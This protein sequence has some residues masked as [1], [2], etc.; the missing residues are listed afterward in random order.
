MRAL[1]AASA[2]AVLTA[3]F[4]PGNPGAG[5]DPDAGST[6]GNATSDAGTSDAGTSDAGI[7][8]AGSG[9][10]SA[11]AALA[12]SL[13][14]NPQFL[15]G[16]GND[17]RGAPDYD[18]NKDGAYTL[19]S[20]LDL[21]YAYLAGLMGSGGW[22]DWNA[23]GTFVNILADTAAAHGVTPMFTLYSMA[24]SGEGNLS[25]L[26]NDQF[27]KPYWDGAK[28]LFQRLG[29]FDKPAL[30][31][32]EPDFWAFTQG[33]QPDPTAMPVHVKA[34]A[35]DCADLPDHLAGMG[36]CLVRL[37]RKYAPKAKI[38]FH[39]SPWAAANGADVGRYLSA[40]G[41]ADADLLVV[42]MSDRDSGC[43]EAHVDPNCQRGSASDAWYWDETNQG[44][45]NFHQ[46]LAWAA[47]LST[48]ANKPLLWWQLPLG[49][50]ADQRGG[51]AGHYR[52]N[53]VRYLFSHTAEFVAAGGVGAVF[54]VGAA[55]QT[56]IETDGNQ[57]RTAVAAYLANPTRL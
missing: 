49:V 53:R 7:S 52:D 20:T 14:R 9:S 36:K 38:G 37:G 22:P 6:A 30:V 51:T 41:A 23:G 42:D 4:P 27:M 19:G 34:L 28:L 29:A 16:L 18:H 12:T 45:P 8:D 48:A 5:I 40:L 13:G 2:A 32:L 24:A 26:T 10:A 17:L 35:P 47:A 21:H 33:A 43:F 3:C 54:G 11:A 31:H 55:N 25:V 44:S 50:P 39:A 1:L 56:T 15:F 57:F 46:H